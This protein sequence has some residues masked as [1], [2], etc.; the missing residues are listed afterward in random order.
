MVR[1]AEEVNRLSQY[2]LE[3]LERELP[4]NAAFLFGSYVDGNPHEGSDI[5]LAIF[6]ADLALLT[7]SQKSRLQLH[8]QRHCA[9]DLELHLY[10][11]N[12]LNKARRTN[13]FGYLLEHGK[14]LR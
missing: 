8:I 6:T 4:I 10:S 1:S 5:D 12:A 9:L 13:F 11:L 3:T 7:I 2:A 14:R